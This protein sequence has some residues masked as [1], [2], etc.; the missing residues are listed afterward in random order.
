MTVRTVEDAVDDFFARYLAAV[1]GAALAEDDPD[2]PTPCA[3]SAA[4]ADGMI[5]WRPVRQ[6]SVCALDVL[7]D[8]LGA[9]PHADAV[10]WLTRWWALPIEARLGEVH[11]CLDTSA[12]A[13]GSA[14]QIVR[15]ARYARAHAGK[16]GASAIPLAVGLLG[17]VFALRNDTGEVVFE[18]LGRPSRALGCGLG[19]WLEALSPLAL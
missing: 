14:R 2:E 12:S 8:A 17:G 3:L 1:G 16:G 5:R 4:D 15:A 9:Q 19:A 10:V 13:D 6:S 18:H 7:K 11:L